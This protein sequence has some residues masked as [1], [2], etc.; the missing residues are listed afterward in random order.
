MQISGDQRREK[1]DEHSVSSSALCA[2]AHWG[3][4]SSI[5]ETPVI[6][7]IDRSVLDTPPSRGMTARMAYAGIANTIAIFEHDAPNFLG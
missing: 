6:E 5:P 7:P 3:G 1:A 2:I 4:R